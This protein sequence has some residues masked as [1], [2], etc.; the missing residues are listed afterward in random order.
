MPGRGFA[1]YPGGYPAVDCT[2]WSLIAAHGADRAG[3]GLK[4]ALEWLGEKQGSDGSL[5][6]DGSQPGSVWPT[7]IGFMAW[8]LFDQKQA[9]DRARVFMLSYEGFRLPHDSPV[10]NVKKGDPVGWPWSMDVSSWVEPTTLAILALQ[11]DPD[12]READRVEEALRYLRNVQL[13]GGGWNY[14]NSVVMGTELRPMMESTGQACV[15]LAGQTEEE[16]VGKALELLE[17]WLIDVRTPL[18]V[19]WALLALSAW[20]RRPDNAEEIIQETLQA[21]YPEF[22][23]RLDLVALLTIASRARMGLSDWLKQEVGA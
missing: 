21:E 13:P 12:G 8:Q 20:G 11:T 22:P 1:G 5:L 2:A 14:G 18:A 17:N 16:E 15:A 10:T 3:L 7:P 9:A 23:Y 4:E 19:A 6:Y